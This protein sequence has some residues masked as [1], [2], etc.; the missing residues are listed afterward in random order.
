MT[1]RCLRSLDPLM[2]RDAAT[3]IVLVD[4]GSTDDTAAT[5]A[6]LDVAWR[7]RLRVLRQSVNLGVARGRNVGLRA[8]CG[9][10][11]MLLDNDT[12]A[13]ADAICHLRD[14]LASDPTIGVIG[15]RLMS[16]QGDVQLSAKPFPSLRLKVRHFLHRGSV[17]P[18][19]L[20]EMAKEEPCYLIG[21]CQMFRREV[22]ERVGEL[23][24]AIFFGPEDADWCL[25]VRAA[26]RRIV[27]D[28]TVGITHD[29]RRATTRSLRARFTRLTWLHIRALLHFWHL[30]GL[31]SR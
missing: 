7:D 17:L 3:E 16:P 11:L 30:H 14:R 9:D 19:E 29:Y 28:P 22:M 31:G 10:V 4:N 2:R 24:E 13:D 15:C 1:E 20:A 18:E 25:R 26:G 27:Y 6:T 23:D 21:A 5:L 12:I 8:A